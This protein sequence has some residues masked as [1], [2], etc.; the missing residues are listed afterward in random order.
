[1]LTTKKLKEYQY[2]CHSVQYKDGI[3]VDPRTNMA[4]SQMMMVI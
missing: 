1:M 4:T 2:M 3:F